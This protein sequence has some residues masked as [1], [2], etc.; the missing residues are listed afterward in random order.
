MD[1]AEALA[2]KNAYEKSPIDHGNVPELTED[3]KKAILRTLLTTGRYCEQVRILEDPPFTVELCTRTS[4]E[5]L[6]VRKAF[7]E[8][9]IPALA[10][11]FFF[12][13][14]LFSLVYS[15]KSINGKPVQLDPKKPIPERAKELADMIPAPLLPKLLQKFS[16]FEIKVLQ[17][18]DP[19]FLQ[20][21]QQQTV[22]SG[23]SSNTASQQ[24][25]SPN[26]AA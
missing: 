11:D 23:Q 8:D 13:L 9:G 1:L 18:V 7:E 26:R 3:E 21:L 17:A 2:R 22:A 5:D 16:E 6:E 24:G 14:G 4:R 15:L 20:R 25:G 19:T 12:K 10:S